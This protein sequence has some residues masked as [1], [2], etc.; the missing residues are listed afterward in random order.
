[1]K[2]EK[3]G[4]CG[5]AACA[6]A[7]PTGALRMASDR[8]G[9]RY[10]EVDPARCT[11]CGRCEAVCPLGRERA[12]DGGRVC[13]GARAKEEAVRLGGSSGG[14]FSVLAEYVF[15]RRGAVFGAAF[16]ESM[17]VVHREAR[18]MAELEALRQTKYVQSRL[19]GVYRRIEALLREGT[20]VLFCGT[21]C[22]AYGLKRFLGR[23]WP[24]LIVADLV[25]Y[26]VPSPGLWRDYTAALE[27]RR[28]P[29]TAFSFRDKRNRDHGHTCAYTA[30]GKEY[31][32]SLGSNPY[33]GMYFSN[34]SIRPSCHACEFASPD[35]ESD[36]TLGDFWGVEAVRPE[37]DDGMGI[38]LVLL[39]TDKARK[40]WAEARES[41]EYFPCEEEAVLQPRLRGPTPP[42]RFRGLF[43]GLYRVLP[44]GGLFF[45]FEKSR[46]AAGLWRRLKR[47]AG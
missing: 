27:R 5:C 40:I 45:L 42:S 18:S 1:M 31:A 15:R 47:R 28:G 20:W 23:D 35:R 13:F 39:H 19:D 7:C 21:P 3:A 6:D 8:E 44:A 9:F 33:C 11:R 37:A 38:S 17:E 43:M 16:N 22:Q 41:L 12:G 32:E 46:A 26:G 36:F 2:R 24:R 25:C 10:P 4:C 29:L 14:V 34:L 30:G